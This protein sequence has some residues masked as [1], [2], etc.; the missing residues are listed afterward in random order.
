MNSLVSVDGK[1]SEIQVY[2]SGFQYNDLFSYKTDSD[3][4]GGSV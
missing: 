2:F 4:F 3:V 1:Y